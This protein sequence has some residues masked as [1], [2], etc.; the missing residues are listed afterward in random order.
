[1]NDFMDLTEEQKTEV[2]NIF[3][4]ALDLSSKLAAVING[5]HP[6]TQSGA[7]VFV[8]AAVVAR[9]VEN[10]RFEDAEAAIAHYVEGVRAVLEDQSAVSLQR[11]KELKEL[12]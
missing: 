6:A 12:Q 2:D 4:R 1:M 10:Q 3:K 9:D 8:M 11:T 5:E 7:V